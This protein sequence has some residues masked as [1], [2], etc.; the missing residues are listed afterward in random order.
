MDGLLAGFSGLTAGAV[1][2]L[3]PNTPGGITTTV[4]SVTG[5]KIQAVGT[6]F[7]TTTLLLDIEQPVIA[8]ATTAPL[9]VASGNSFPGSP[10]LYDRF[11]RTDRGIDYYYDGARWLSMPLLPLGINGV[12]G[13]VSPRFNIT[14]LNPVFNSSIYLET[15]TFLFTIDTTFDAANYWIY[16]PSYWDSTGT[17]H[18]IVS[19][20][21]WNGSRSPGVAYPLSIDLYQTF[22]SPLVSNSN[23]LRFGSYISAVGSPGAF[24]GE[25]G[26][27]FYR[28]VG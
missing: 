28:L 11:Y 13:T 15:A 21:T 14:G 7:S 27:W 9:T 2:F 19:I 18:A 4:P 23:P 1:Y 24:S 8:A 3:D 12:G 20:N 5:Q 25:N 22:G 6:A 17:R 26:F 16:E 10:N